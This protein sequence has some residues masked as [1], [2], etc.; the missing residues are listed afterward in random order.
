MIEEGK[1][2][3]M[4][5]FMKWW[6]EELKKNYEALRSFVKHMSGVKREVEKVKNMRKNVALSCLDGIQ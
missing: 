4:V 3:K 6:E 1:R 5:S 2:A